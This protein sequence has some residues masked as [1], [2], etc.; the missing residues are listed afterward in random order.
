MLYFLLLSPI[1]WS[2]PNITWSELYALKQWE[3]LTEQKH[4]VGTIT[5]Y[6]GI[7]QDFP[8]FVG[9]TTTH[10]PADLLLS[11]ASQAEEALQWSTAGV[12]EAKE[13]K[14]TTEYV[15][16]YQY[17]DVPV[18][19]DRYWILRG[20]FETTKDATNKTTKMFH[21]ENISHKYPEFQ[22]EIQSKNPYALEP[23]INVGAWIFEELDD[24]GL[25]QVSYYICSHPGGSVPVALQSI[26]TE[27]TLPDNIKDLLVEGTKRSK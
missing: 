16:Y 10:L 14:R 2:L 26:A 22:K 13:L 6:K 11:I 5:V 25:L 4:D 3:E 23:P 19:T 24:K 7:I 27:N 15:D 17:L 20:F 1:A 9:K 8:C 12:T 21:W 18:F